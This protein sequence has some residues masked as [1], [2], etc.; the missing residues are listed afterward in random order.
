MTAHLDS[1]ANQMF[2]FA[3]STQ[4]FGS[5]PG[6]SLENT[7]QLEHRDSEPS[8]AFSPNKNIVFYQNPKVLNFS[9]NKL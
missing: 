5:Q 9:F 3:K 2:N 8:A 4:S 7:Q 6:P 1:V